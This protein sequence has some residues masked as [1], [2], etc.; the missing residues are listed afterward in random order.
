MIIATIPSRFELILMLTW[1]ICFCSTIV[2]SNLEDGKRASAVRS[3]SPFTSRCAGNTRESQ[4]RFF[5][6]SS[7]SFY[8]QGED[9]FMNAFLALES[10]KLRPSGVSC[11]M[12][13]VGGNVGEYAI[14][15]KHYAD[16]HNLHACAVFSYEPV[17]TTFD[18]LR[19]VGTEHN[20]TAFNKG[21]SDKEG[22]FNITFRETGDEGA[23]FAESAAKN[24]ANFDGVRQAKVSVTTVDSQ[25]RL[26]FPKA[27][28][29]LEQVYVPILK[30]DVES[31]ESKV[32][33][34]MPETLRA[35]QVQVIQWERHY[36]YALE[37]T[38][39][40]E[41]EYVAAFGYVVYILGV[42]RATESPYQ[43][44]K[45]RLLLIRIDGSFF[46]DTIANVQCRKGVTINLVAVR[47][48]H[49]F[50]RWAS[51]N[52]S[53]CRNKQRNRGICKCDEYD[54]VDCK[55]AKRR[56]VGG[57]GRPYKAR[58]PQFNVN[59]KKCLGRKFKP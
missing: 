18:K 2:R 15:L 34:G 45:S 49:P 35:G 19:V 53:I 39:A 52:A 33:A 43:Q 7:C 59:W 48:G 1:I 24:L 36:I 20:F 30:I 31:L 10:Q 37:K 14:S 12:L 22:F 51:E 47:I 3:G 38:L 9:E 58:Y 42:A 56:G 46:T 28:G 44:R 4:V 17:P 23:T 41:V 11:V 21:V 54:G 29:R 32:F 13:D 5:Q 55:R 26:N 57:N 16:R 25:L 27:A 40:E 6:R 8:N 50:N